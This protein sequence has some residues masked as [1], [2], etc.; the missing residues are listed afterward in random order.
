VALVSRGIIVSVLAWVA[1]SS[2]AAAQMPPSSL[3]STMRSPSWAETSAVRL[4]GIDVS[5]A[6][7]DSGLRIGFDRRFGG[8]VMGVKGDWSSGQGCARPDALNPLSSCGTVSW[9]STAEGRIGYAWDR[10]VAFTQGGA[11][12]SQWDRGALTGTH[13]GFDAAKS[14]STGW[15]LG[16]GLEYALGS[17]WS[18]RAEYNYFD[19][20]RPEPGS[21][22]G[23]TN[24]GDSYDVRNHML[25][26]GLKRRM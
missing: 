4:Y 7:T 17:A 9:Q 21:V 15:V 20:G 3:R 24:L 13:A 10:L 8:W 12:F 19:Y 22:P 26:L 11:V 2:A 18:V 16:G 25:M 1:F 6:A 14:I 23:T 5:S